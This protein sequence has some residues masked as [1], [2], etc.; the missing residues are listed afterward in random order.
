MEAQESCESHFGNRLNEKEK[1]YISKSIRMVENAEYPYLRDFL[2]GYTSEGKAFISVGANQLGELVAAVLDP[3]TNRYDEYPISFKS[4]NYELAETWHC[5]CDFIQYRKSGS[6]KQ[7]ITWISKSDLGINGFTK[8]TEPPKTLSWIV[9]KT[10][11]VDLD[12]TERTDTW[13]LTK[14]H[15]IG[16]KKIPN[17]E[18]IQQL[19]DERTKP[20]KKYVHATFSSYPNNSMG[21]WNHGI[22]TNDVPFTV[23]G[24]VK[25]SWACDQTSIADCFGWRILKVNE[26]SVLDKESLDAVFAGLSI[27]QPVVFTM[28]E[29][30]GPSLNDVDEARK[31]LKDSHASVRATQGELAKLE[32]EALEIQQRIIRTQNQLEEAVSVVKV[33]EQLLKQE[34]KSYEMKHTAVEVFKRWLGEDE[35]QKF[36]QEATHKKLGEINLL[37]LQDLDEVEQK[38]FSS[39]ARG[40][41]DMLTKAKDAET[42]AEASSAMLSIDNFQKIV[43]QDSSEQSADKYRLECLALHLAAK[44]DNPDSI[45]NLIQLGA[46]PNAM[47]NNGFPKAVRYEVSASKGF[48]RSKH[49]GIY[50]RSGDLTLTSLRQGTWAARHTS[51]SKFIGSKIVR[52][53]SF[54]VGSEEEFVSELNSLEEGAQVVFT[55]EKMVATTGNSAL[56]TA[57]EQGSPDAIMSLIEGGANPN[58]RNNCGMMPLHLASKHGKP[59]VV[60][61]LLEYG[62][63][64]GAALHIAA[65]YDQDQVIQPLVLYGANV[66]ERN[67]GQTPLHVASTYGAVKVVNALI[68]SNAKFSEKD[69]QGKTALQIA[70]EHG[71]IA[72]IDVLVSSGQTPLHAAAAQDTDEVAHALIKWKGKINEKDAHGK[73]PLQIAAEHGHIAVIDLLQEN[74]AAVDTTDEQLLA[75]LRINKDGS[76]EAQPQRKGNTVFEDLGKGGIKKEKTTVDGNG[77]GD[78]QRKGDTALRAAAARRKTKTC[79]SLMRSGSSPM[80][81]NHIGQTALHASVRQGLSVTIYKMTATFKAL[82]ENIPK[83]SV[84]VDQSGVIQEIDNQMAPHDFKQKQGWRIR[85]ITP[86]RADISKLLSQQEL[87]E[88]GVADLSDLIKTVGN[89][90]K[91]TEFGF[92]VVCQKHIPVGAITLDKNGIIRAVDEQMAPRILHGQEGSKILSVASEGHVMTWKRSSAEMPQSVW[93]VYAENLFKKGKTDLAECLES[94]KGFSDEHP[95]I[96]KFS[97]SVF[98]QPMMHCLVRKGSELFGNDDGQQWLKSILNAQDA[99]GRTALHMAA[100]YG[101]TKAA[102]SL[103]REGCDKNLQDVARRSALHTALE[104]GNTEVVDILVNH[105]V[106]FELQDV[107]G[108]TPI[109][110]AAEQGLSTSITLLRNNGANIHAFDYEKRTP[111]HVAAL[112][113]RS[114]VVELLIDMGCKPEEVDHGGRTPLHLSAASGQGSAASA[115]MC[116]F[117]DPEVLN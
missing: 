76:S 29:E 61:P 57:A 101:D 1:N 39:T 25:A 63:K 97:P 7:E 72:V 112:N 78:P 82:A 88:D 51:L 84:V 33:S 116:K 28:Q 80:E 47:E 70:S 69:S 59:T 9:A 92:H 102:S 91:D 41:L 90:S 40:A 38:G 94:Q 21:N 30:P 44:D 10:D 42:V 111:L 86:Y 46:N 117:V 115:L 93:S 6:Q 11:G 50:F 89:T 104:E 53:N 35:R 68:K 16:D 73:T 43:R 23:S 56:H 99:Q 60:K 18:T 55:V 65:M 45:R 103:L 95:L 13:Y 22:I 83:G 24:V 71:H 109:H 66:N 4:G 15:S 108:R 54:H 85:L 75:Q 49:Y 74:G 20:T 27:G 67:G 32:K 12:A 98:Y 110:V 107:V 48:E 26:R 36:F 87:F 19:K 79:L 58:Q 81:T 37:A 106:G 5:D 34:E 96:I 114:E 8:A 2:A 3:E 14:H 105:K 52:L 62:A 31:R 64:P 100:M 77:K 17:E 113:G